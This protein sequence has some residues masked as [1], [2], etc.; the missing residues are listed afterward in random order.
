AGSGALLVSGIFFLLALFVYL[1]FALKR[2]FA[3]S[4][5]GT[6]LRMTVVCLTAFALFQL[7]HYFISSHSGR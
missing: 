5:L 6:L 4:W 2:V 3:F 1:A 7:I